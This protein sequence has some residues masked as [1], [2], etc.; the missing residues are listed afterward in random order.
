M[1]IWYKCPKHQEISC[2]Q[3]ERWEL[4]YIASYKSMLYTLQLQFSLVQLK[5]HLQQISSIKKK[6]RLLNKGVYSCCA[7]TLLMV[8]DYISM[9]LL[10]TLKKDC[11][12]YTV[13]S[14]SLGLESEH[15][16]YIIS[17]QENLLE[18]LVKT[19]LVCIYS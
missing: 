1:D 10:I 2:Y 9:Y 13:I 15:N 11:Y 5:S 7:E 19:S 8:T 6:K 4:G 16:T 17:I 12:C 18:F 3:R 14:L